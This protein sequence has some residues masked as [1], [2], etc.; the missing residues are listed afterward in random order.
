MLLHRLQTHPVNISLNQPVSERQQPIEDTFTYQNLAVHYRKTGSGPPLL[1]LHG[2]GVS[3][4]V[5][6]PLAKSLSSGYTCYLVDFPGFGRSD[7]LPQAW[8][9]DDY[10]GMTAA[11]IREMDLAGCDVLAHSF[12]ARVT[13]KLCAHR[14]E[15]D[16]VHRL[17]IT[18]GAGMKPRVRPSIYVRR[19]LVKLLK[20]PFALL[21]ARLRE[22]GLDW[23]RSTRLWQVLGSSD[24]RQLDGVMRETF[25]K[26]VS[27]HLDDL[28]PD[29][30]HPVL[31]LWGEKDEATPLYQGRRMESRMPDAALVTL[32]N[33]GH[34]AFLDQPRAFERILR[35][36][37]THRSK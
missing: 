2:W 36:F 22:K 30:R 7:T 1:L 28:L 33:A 25:V 31:L 3:G 26:V 14:E 35:A 20:S 4:E 21:P 10:A 8:S 17:L 11:F 16:L 27:E 15:K 34:Y 13:L 5:L 23:L 32:E 29:V 37:F 6:L 9:V 18:G 19:A 12:G 24:Y